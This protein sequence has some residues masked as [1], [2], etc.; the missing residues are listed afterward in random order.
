MDRIQDEKLVKHNSSNSVLGKNIQFYGAK[1]GLS[2][3]TN[4]SE[5]VPRCH[6]TYGIEIL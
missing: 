4:V 3:L 2:A 5:T 1:S 6:L